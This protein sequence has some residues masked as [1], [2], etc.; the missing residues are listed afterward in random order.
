MKPFQAHMHGDAFKSDG[1]LGDL[2]VLLKPKQAITTH[3]MLALCCL[4]PYYL[5][6]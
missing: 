5:Q 1:H 3:A 2:P 6:G 4:D